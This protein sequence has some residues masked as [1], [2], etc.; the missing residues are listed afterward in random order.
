MR[1][2]STEELLRETEERYRRLAELSSD[3]I[4]VQSEG[5]VAYVNAAGLKLLGVTCLEEVLGRPM[6]DFV[7]P[8]FHEAA[9]AWMRQVE[10]G[11]P[12]TLMEQRWVRLDGR[13]VDVEA[14]S[15]PITYQGRP[16]SQIVLRDVTGRKRTGSEIRKAEAKYRRLVEQIPAATYRQDLGEGTAITYVSPQIEAIIGYSPEKYVSDPELWMRIIHPDDRERVLA[17]DG[18]VGRSGEPFS[19]E[20]RK[21][22]KDGR[23]VWVR[24][25]AVVVD[26]ENG[27]PLYWQGIVLDVTESK[28]AEQGLRRSEARNRAILE[29]SPDLMFLFNRAGEF[30]DFRAH[31]TD[32]LY[33][34]SESIVGSKLIDVMPTEVAHKALHF[35][36]RT[37]D[38]GE[39]QTFEYELSAPEGLRQFEARLVKSGADE[40]PGRHS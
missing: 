15:A 22:A 27:E 28:L 8:D 5:K 24:D 4:A 30:L 17:E 38:S 20:Y 31:G 1:R 3:A 10:E 26:D 35:I 13:V 23:T 36:G 25:E 37:L 18:R 33:V 32:E 19:M 39:A 11:R 14:A 34:P 16:S 7:H 12:A 21:L 2:E 29:A 40:V 6:L 9:R